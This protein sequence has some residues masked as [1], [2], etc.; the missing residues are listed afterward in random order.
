[1]SLRFIAAVA[2]A[3]SLISPAF[4]ETVLNR[5]NIAEPGTV[6]PQKYSTTYESHIQLDLFETL[7]TND[8][9][10]AYVPGSAESWKVSDD[11]RVYTFKLRPNLKWSDG[12]PITSADFVY[13]FRRAIDPKTHSWYA[14]MC[15]NIK[16][17]KAVNEGKMKP[18]A[19]GVSA[20][21][22]STFVVTLIDPSAT[23]IYLMAHPMLA[24]APKHVIDK[25]GEKW[26]KPGTMVSNG[27]YKLAEWRPNDHIK[28][29]KNPY[30]YDAAN[31]KIDAVKF[32]P[33]E[34]DAAAVKRLRAGEIDTNPRFPANEVDR[35]KKVLPAG[36]VRTSPANATSYL[37]PNHKKPPF[38]D[39]RVRRALSLA[40]DREAI[41]NKI[42]R[43]GELPSYSIVSPVAG[44]Y[45][46]LALDFK[47]KPL[48]ERQAEAR[49]LLA[50]A[51]YGPNKPLKIDFSHRVGISNKRVAI[52]VQDMFKAIG[53]QTDLLANDVTVHYARLREGDFTFADAG[54][55]AFG[56]D[57]EFFTYLLLSGSTEIN[58]GAY[59]NPAFDKKSD[60]AA[61]T[62]DMAKRMALFHEAEKIA[63]DDNAVIP[64]YVTVNRNLVAPRVKGWVMNP[65]DGH[66]TRFMSIDPK[67]P[68]KF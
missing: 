44:N 61:K 6:D 16:N 59:N 60:E 46:P 5:G 43:N 26:T 29:V 8:A 19:L 49:K 34:D 22:A 2:L 9:A 21:D 39:V 15:Y 68:T 48:A 1:M 25:F 47:G 20:P 53:V 7:V 14:N 4:A 65:S 62:M 50:A 42:L 33:I 40:I 57:P 13:G 51:G 17:A 30:F 10:G 54:W 64:V 35:L 24:P 11:G 41:A 55:Y 67:A 23:L 12:T 45:T 52:A 37:V 63:L 31:V 28:L 3:S 18:E 58:Y 36:V 27:P 56:P 66:P 32:F 38:N